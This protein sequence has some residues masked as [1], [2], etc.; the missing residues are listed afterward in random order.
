MQ[1]DLQLSP[2]ER[3]LGTELGR[4][5]LDLSDPARAKAEVGEL[6][7]QLVTEGAFT[8]LYRITWQELVVFGAVAEAD[9]VLSESG[10]HPDWL[11]VEDA[12][13]FCEQTFG[14]GAI[15][16]ADLEVGLDDTVPDPDALLVAQD[17]FTATGL[18]G[19]GG[20]DKGAS[21][22]ITGGQGKPTAVIN[23]GL[24]AKLTLTDGNMEDLETGSVLVVVMG[25]KAINKDALETAPLS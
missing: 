6:L 25:R 15:S 18:L 1:D 24:T 2:G 17:V 11:I 4:R 9:L 12:F 10:A 23:E 8:K 20:A 3:R 21:L 7:R 19:L 13:L 16:A 5:A 14:G 22:I